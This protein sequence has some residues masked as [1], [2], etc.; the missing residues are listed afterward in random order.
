MKTL[1]TL[2]KSALFVFVFTCKCI[3]VNA[4]ADLLITPFRVVFEGTKQMEELSVSNIS[5]D[6]ARYNISFIQYRMTE[7]GAFQ[8]IDKP[9]TG[10]MFSDKFLRIF[11]RAVTLAPNETQMV[12]VQVK[13]STDMIDGEY[14]SHLYFRSA[15]PND[16]KAITSTTK[17]TAVG[18]KLTPI[19][20]ISIPIII[21]KGNLSVTTNI[22]KV[23]LSQPTDTSK[24]L[25]FVIHRS[26]TES[27]FGDIYVTLIDDSGKS[28]TAGVMRGVSVYT[29]NLT[30]TI[31]VKLD[32]KNIPAYKGT[33]KI[34]YGLNSPK[35][36]TYCTYDYTIK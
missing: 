5:K 33:L 16:N 29:P 18:I 8:Q 12:K 28:Y 35:K 10:Q 22:D 7:N 3:S 13:Q 19:Y 23:E 17:D 34:N 6:T 14:R 24:Q 1:P 9:D 30:R 36:V 20:G 32:T 2:I 15:K 21:R 25:T 26:G 4:Q 11:P 27:V 31:S